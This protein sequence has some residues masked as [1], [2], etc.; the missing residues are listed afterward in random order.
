LT[1]VLEDPS[2]PEDVEAPT[3]DWPLRKKDSAQKK[4][5]SW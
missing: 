5:S 1:S 2:F 4:T 3:L